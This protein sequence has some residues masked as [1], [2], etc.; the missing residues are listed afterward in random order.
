M[1][2]RTIW[3]A[4][5][6]SLMF[7]SSAQAQSLSDQSPA[8]TD[9]AEKNLPVWFQSDELLAA[10][11]TPQDNPTTNAGAELGRA[12]FYDRRLSHNDTIACASCHQQQNG[13]T[14]PNQQ[15]VGFQGERTQRHSMSLANIR[16]LSLIHI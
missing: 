8:Y 14:D 2:R 5:V 7:A 11:N 10:D 6:V 3:A 12:L 16:Y 1:H 15:S 13:F 9:Y 4:A